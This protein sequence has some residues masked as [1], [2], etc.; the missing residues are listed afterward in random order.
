MLTCLYVEALL[1]DSELADQ[2][3]ELWDVGMIPDGMAAMAWLIL[4]APESRQVRTD[5]G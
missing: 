5:K 3:W 1:A 4:A 2:V